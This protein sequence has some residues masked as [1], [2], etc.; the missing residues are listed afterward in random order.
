MGKPKTKPKKN[1]LDNMFEH[2]MHSTGHE[3]MKKRK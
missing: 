3:H 2:I 1:L